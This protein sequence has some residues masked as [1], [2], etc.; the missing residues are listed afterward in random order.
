MQHC[1]VPSSTKY[2]ATCYQLKYLT[3]YN[4][5][6]DKIKSHDLLIKDMLTKFRFFTV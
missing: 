1:A 4:L 2:H 5:F 3:G 6:I